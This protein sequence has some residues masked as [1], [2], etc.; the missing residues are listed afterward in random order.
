MKVTF[1]KA[2]ITIYEN[3]YLYCLNNEQNTNP[4]KKFYVRCSAQT[5]T[6]I[7]LLEKPPAVNRFPAIESLL[8]DLAEN[9]ENSG[10]KFRRL[11]KF[12]WV[13]RIYAPGKNSGER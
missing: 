6:G 8:R 11:T 13:Y 9:S 10:G 5:K 2:Y 12:R 3:I 4:K 1:R 7:G